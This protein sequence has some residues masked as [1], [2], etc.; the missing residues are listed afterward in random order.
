MKASFCPHCVAPDAKGAKERQYQ[1]LFK[2]LSAAT[3]DP[4]HDLALAEAGGP[5]QA[6]ANTMNNPRIAAGW[7]FYA[8]IVAH[9]VTR[10]R[11]PLSNEEEVRGLKNFHKPRLDLECLYGGG[12]V[13]QPYFY[14]AEDIDKF[15]MGRNDKDEPKDIARNRQGIALIAD[16]RNDTYL[17]ISQLHLALQ[18]LHNVLVDNVREAGTK[19]ADVFSEAQR[20]TRWHHQWVVLNEFLP[21]HVGED[22]LSKLLAHNAAA[23]DEAFVPVEFAAGAFRF[24]H[25]QVRDRYDV[26][27][28]LR[29]VPIF[30]D[31]VGQQPVTA[32]RALEMPYIFEL[33]GDIEPLASKRIDASYSEAMMNLP[34]ALTGELDDPKQSALAYRDLQRGASL[35]LPSGEAVAERLGIEPLDRKALALPEGLCEEDTPLSYYVQKEAFVQTQG[36]HL[37]EVGGRLVGGVLVDLLYSDPTSYLVQEPSWQPTL[38]REGEGFGIADLLRA[39]GAAEPS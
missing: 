10:D 9:D 22:V 7:P 29:D 6:D 16:A 36:L 5:M 13:A 11:A 24:G 19:D 21:L 30:P 18:K 37:G 33:G 12:P 20:L 35:G 34:K 3:F 38:S 8:Q 26:N 31:L 39:A 28:Q 1:R 15:L 25:A 14:D 4:A 17:F 2:D 23:V 27:A 32:A